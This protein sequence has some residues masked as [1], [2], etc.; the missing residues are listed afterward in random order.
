MKYI[1]ST[2]GYANE[3]CYKCPHGVLHEPV[4]ETLEWDK[5]GK[6]K[7]HRTCVD[8]S[9]CHIKNNDK[10]DCKCIEA[11]E[12]HEDRPMVCDKCGS[13]NIDSTMDIGFDIDDSGEETQHLDSC[14]DCGAERIWCDRILDFRIKIVTWGKW[15]P[16]KGQ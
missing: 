12:K 4:P 1:C 13:T 11:H 5:E 14:C 6:G 2:V 16:L 9:P 10:R 8:R 7:P 15:M 3:D